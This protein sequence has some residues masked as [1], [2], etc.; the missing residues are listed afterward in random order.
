MVSKNN[1]LQFTFL[2]GLE[3]R[4]SKITVPYDFGFLINGH[5]LA[6]SLPQ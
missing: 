5:H 6:V 2:T 3:D 1:N 4:K